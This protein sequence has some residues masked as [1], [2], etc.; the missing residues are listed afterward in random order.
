[1]TKDNSKQNKQSIL[2]FFHNHP[3][4]KVVIAVAIFIAITI[5]FFSSFWIKIKWLIAVLDIIYIIITLCILYF[6]EW[7]LINYLGDLLDKYS[8]KIWNNYKVNGW[9]NLS[10]IERFYKI[11]W[12]DDYLHDL[13]VVFNKRNIFLSEEQMNSYIDSS[14]NVNSILLYELL[15][16]RLQKLPTTEMTML[17]HYIE[18]KSS[19]NTYQ[20]NITLN[21]V[22]KTILVIST[23]AFVLTISGTK[24]EVTVGTVTIKNLSNKL[25]THTIAQIPAIFIMFSLLILIF[26]TT[27]FV[28][29]AFYNAKHLR[30]VDVIHQALADAYSIKSN[31]E[32]KK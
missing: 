27:I 22:G 21:N 29:L 19:R 4:I 14:G 7:K 10:D 20:R 26:I 13:L 6:V 24:E 30:Y 3:F 18:M 16:S 12:K 2:C 25:I 15:V 1:M 32:V 17:K 8:S 11:N 5:A 31:N 9:K 28:S 23:V